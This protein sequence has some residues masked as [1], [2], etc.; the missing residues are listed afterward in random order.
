MPSFNFTF[1]LMIILGISMYF[2]FF[3]LFTFIFS[4]IIGKIC[5]RANSLEQNLFMLKEKKYLSL[6][7]IIISILLLI[8]IIFLF[9]SY[10]GLFTPIFSDNIFGEKTTSQVMTSLF[11]FIFFTVFYILIVNFF[12]KRMKKMPEVF[13]KNSRDIKK[14]YKEVVGENKL[15]LFILKLFYLVPIAVLI[16]DIF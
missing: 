14:E 10:V 5:Y 15:Y 8:F 4:F 12:N 3:Y 11:C 1:I 9:F 16:F 7:S 13:F 6:F 2:L